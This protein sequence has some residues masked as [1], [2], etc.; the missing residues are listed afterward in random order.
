MNE[1]IEIIQ[2]AA[3]G[4][5]NSKQGL[6]TYEDD[7]GADHGDGQQVGRITAYNAVIHKCA[8]ILGNMT[9]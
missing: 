2:F 4:I 1:L 5:A 6:D 3:E 8:T 7:A 9:R